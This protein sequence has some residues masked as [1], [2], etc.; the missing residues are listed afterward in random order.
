MCPEA[1]EQVCPTACAGVSLHRL[2]P[3]ELTG[4][5][6]G[7]WP[8]GMPWCP[9]TGIPGARQRYRSRFRPEL[10]LEGSWAVW[11]WELKCLNVAIGNVGRSP[12]SCRAKLTQYW[13][14]WFF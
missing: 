6:L 3:W 10:E 11:A 8:A 9:S 2:L 7:S 14:L 5:V 1:V 13:T 4:V 12:E